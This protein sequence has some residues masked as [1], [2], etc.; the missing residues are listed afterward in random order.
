MSKTE[1]KS[2][3]IPAVPKP[4][5]PGLPIKIDDILTETKCDIE[6]FSRMMKGLNGFCSHVDPGNQEVYDFSAAVSYL[7]DIIQVDAER[8]AARLGKALE[9]GAV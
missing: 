5:K 2:T 3:T 6:R 1:K 7:A 9:G 8:I 4:E